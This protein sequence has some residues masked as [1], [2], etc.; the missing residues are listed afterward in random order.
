MGVSS[1]GVPMPMNQ[2][3]FGIRGNPGY[4]GIFTYWSIRTGI[5]ELRQ[6]AHGTIFA[7]ITLQTFKLVETLLSSVIICENVRIDRE[8]CYGTCTQ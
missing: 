1:L 4:P 8:A 2:S 6:Q 5:D 3:C 7:K